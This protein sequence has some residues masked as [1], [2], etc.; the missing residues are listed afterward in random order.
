MDTTAGRYN[1]IYSETKRTGETAVPL[2]T[3]RDF[4]ILIQFQA[5]PQRFP[6]PVVLPRLEQLGNRKETPQIKQQA[7][8]I[9]G[10]SCFLFHPYKPLGTLRSSQVSG[11]ESWTDGPASCC[12]CSLPRE[13]DVQQWHLLLGLSKMLSFHFQ[14][15]L[16]CLRLTHRCLYQPDFGDK[17]F[18]FST[19]LLLSNA[20]PLS[21]PSC[22]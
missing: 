18:A 5:Q 21:H 16:Q 14:F 3:T 6:N 9:Y 10:F 20:E 2:C 11:F 19:S 17:A 8:R 1:R 7:G 4:D 12:Y 22:V 15:S 13:S